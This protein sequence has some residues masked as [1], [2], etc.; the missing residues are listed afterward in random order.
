MTIR[1]MSPLFYKATVVTH[2]VLTLFPMFMLILLWLTVG[3]A[4]V[5]LG[6]LPIPMVND[7]KTIDNPFFGI[8]YFTTLVLFAFAYPILT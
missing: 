3:Q 6:H 4:S 5:L 7:P 1:H 2:W 8:L